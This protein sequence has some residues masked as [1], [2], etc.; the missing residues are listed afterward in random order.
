MSKSIPRRV[1]KR[2]QTKLEL[3]IRWP[4]SVH[5]KYSWMLYMALPNGELIDLD[6][7]ATMH[8]NRDTLVNDPCDCWAFIGEIE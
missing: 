8:F 6:D 3:W 2:K 4:N 1:P 7:G 5:P